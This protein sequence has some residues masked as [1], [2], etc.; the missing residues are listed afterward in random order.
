MGR[1]DDKSAL[2]LETAGR[3]VL[4]S[5]DTPTAT[6]PTAPAPS[7]ESADALEQLKKLGEL[8]SSG[9]LSDEEFASK[10]AELLDRF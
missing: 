4:D 5:L 3:G 2:G 8:H 9:V 7:N 1:T 6:P 10:K